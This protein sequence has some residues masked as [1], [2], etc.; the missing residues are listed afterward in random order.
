MTLQPRTTQQETYTSYHNIP[1]TVHPNVCM[2]TIIIREIYQR[3][4]VIQTTREVNHTRP[5]HVLQCLNG[6]LCL[7]I[8]LRMKGSTKLH[9]CA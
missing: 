3:Q 4:L 7:P 6:A 5:H 2:I 8:S 9:L 1:Q